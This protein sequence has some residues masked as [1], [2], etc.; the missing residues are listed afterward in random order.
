MHPPG[1]GAAAGADDPVY[2]DAL[3]RPNRSL[4]PRGFFWLMVV[5]GVMCF[6]SGIGFVTAG[7]WP[8]M[9]FFGLDVL[10]LYV[11]FRA[12][13]RTGNLYETVK[14][15]GE[16]LRVRRVYPSGRAREWAFQPTWLQIN[17]DDPPEH[18]SQLELRSHGDTLHIGAFLT[19]EERLEVAEALREALDRWRRGLVATPPPCGAGRPAQA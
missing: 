19:P 10:I 13:Y 15:T 16:G 12:S 1:R 4:S 8:V 5:F 11:A 2:F 6:V 18:H 9:G 17:M 3:L 14:L 7:A